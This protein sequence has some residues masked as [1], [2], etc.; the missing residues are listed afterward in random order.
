MQLLKLNRRKLLKI[1]GASLLVLA[2]SGLGPTLTRRR[3]V[4][5]RT[6]LLMGSFGEIQ[7]VHDD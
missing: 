3:K 7:L 6:D 2:G 5:S 1:S 4:F